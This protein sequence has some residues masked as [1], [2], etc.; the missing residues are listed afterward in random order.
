MAL[1]QARFLIG[2]VT[3]E[4]RS[5]DLCRLYRSIFVVET[6]RQISLALPSVQGKHVG[7]QMA[8]PGS[9]PDNL[10]IKQ[11]SSSMLLQALITELVSAGILKQENMMK[12]KQRSLGYAQMLK[13][14]GGS[15]A[16][17]AGSRIEQDLMMVFDILA[18]N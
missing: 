10:L 7:A 14:H 3:S 4:I 8:F 2:V 18:D 13:E 11:S 5:K 16:Q 15:G 17:V 9:E 6:S 1:P 12:I